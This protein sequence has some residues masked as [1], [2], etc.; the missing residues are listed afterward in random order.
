[1][2][3]IPVYVDASESCN[4]LSVFGSLAANR[5]LIKVTQFRCSNPNLAPSGCTQWHF[6]SP[7]GMVKTFNYDGG[8]HLADQRQT[9]CVR[10]VSAWKESS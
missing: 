10:L 2:F 7:A 6:G 9:I 5:W 4:E 1:M 8:V 3:F